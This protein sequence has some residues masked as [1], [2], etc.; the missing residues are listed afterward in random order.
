MS[1]TFISRLALTIRPLSSSN[2]I[3]AASENA[4]QRG[5]FSINKNKTETFPE[6]TTG[7]KYTC[8]NWNF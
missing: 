8:Q 1:V 6:L 7:G 3:A 4:G 2:E 5:F